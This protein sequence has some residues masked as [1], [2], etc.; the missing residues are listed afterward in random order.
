MSHVAVI[1]LFCN[2]RQ[3]R[4]CVIA[5]R[6]HSPTSVK[7]TC[8]KTKSVN[9][10]GC[11]LDLRT[12]EVKKPRPRLLVTLDAVT[13]NSTPLACQKIFSINTRDTTENRNRHCSTTVNTVQYT[14]YNYKVIKFLN[15]KYRTTEYT[16]FSV[17]LQKNTCLISIMQRK[18]NKIL[19]GEIQKLVN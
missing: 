1:Y 4:V 7:G 6:K 5:H 2:S 15:I 19:F 14:N 18:N 12:A 10:N 11:C 8:I 17:P 9:R 13:V 3:K 16:Y